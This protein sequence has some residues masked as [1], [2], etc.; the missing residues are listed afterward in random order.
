M[1]K[2]E[3]TTRIGHPIAS[4]TWFFVCLFFSASFLV[5]G[6]P[7]LVCV[8]YVCVSEKQQQ[9]EC[10]ECC[11][12]ESFERKEGKR[13]EEQSREKLRPHPSGHL[14]FCHIQPVCFFLHC[15]GLGMCICVRVVLG[16]CA[17]RR[18]RKVHFVTH[19]ACTSS[20]DR[21]YH[22]QQPLHHNIPVCFFFFARP[23][24]VS[25]WGVGVLW[26]PFFFLCCRFLAPSLNYKYIIKRP[27]P[28]KG[29]SRASP[30]EHGFS[31]FFF[32]SSSVLF[33]PPRSPFRLGFVVLGLALVLF[34]V[35][36]IRASVHTSTCIQ[37][38]T[39]QVAAEPSRQNIKTTIYRTSVNM[40]V[41]E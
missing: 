15:I 40:R 18:K 22:Q 38:Y 13:R 31:F 24:L 16:C 7:L 20:R 41:S 27:L 14:C 9:Q 29:S 8:G 1:Y 28:Y 4:N 6:F 39:L 34:C 25:C 37:K 36:C 3:I 26:A 21:V 10:I 33:F 30:S 2:K 23:V 12:S 5:F 17:K 11:T 35:S 32:S 19:Q